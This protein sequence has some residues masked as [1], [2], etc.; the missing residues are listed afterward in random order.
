MEYPYL[1]KKFVEEKVKVFISPLNR[2]ILK[3][4]YPETFKICKADDPTSYDFQIYTYQ[5]RFL[6]LIFY[7]VVSRIYKNPLAQ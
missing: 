1:A 3:C 4:E 7:V 2:K 5:E 6:Y